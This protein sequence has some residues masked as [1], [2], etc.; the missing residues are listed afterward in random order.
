[1]N[2]DPLD[3]LNQKLQ[4]L[5]LAALRCQPLTP[6]QQAA[7][8]QLVNAIWQ[9]GRLCRP[10]R[11]NFPGIY[12]DIYA[13]AQQD[14]FLYICQN[15]HK[16]NPER[17]TVMNWINMLLERRFFKEAIPKVLGKPDMKRVCLSDLENLAMPE[18]TKS[19]TDALKEIIEADPDNLFQ[20]AHIR[21]CP[22]A[23]FQALCLRRLSNHSWKRIAAEFDVS[24]STASNFLKRCLDKFAPDLKKYLNGSF[25][26]SP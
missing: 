1:M 3:E 7:L 5:V 8:R 24:I 16:Y 11:G 6:E 25:P 23:T 10:Q 9:S 14:L 4:A 12:E 19:L 18:D 21:D 2:Q 13:E 26:S 22:D 20:S 15:L 17:G